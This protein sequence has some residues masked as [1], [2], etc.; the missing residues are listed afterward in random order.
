VK[1]NHKSIDELVFE[2]RD[3]EI[4]KIPDTKTRLDTIQN[5][6][7]P[8]L[9][10]LTK[11]TFRLL[12]EVYGFDPIQ[13]RLGF[14]YRPSHRKDAVKN[15]DYKEV[16]M[17]LSGTRAKATPLAVKSVQGKPYMFPPTYLLFTIG[18]EGSMRVEF[19]P[20]HYD[21]DRNSKVL[22]ARVLR[23]HTAKYAPFLAQCH[24][25]HNSTW[26]SLDLHEAMTID[27]IEEYGLWL[28]SPAYYFPLTFERGLKELQRAFIALY[29]LFDATLCAARG[30][31]HK[32]PAMLR[33]LEE[34]YDQENERENEES[35]K[36]EEIENTGPINLP[37]LQSYNFVRAGLWW[38][39]LARDKWRCCSCG[40]TAKDDGITLHVDHILPRSKGGADCAENLQ[41]LCQKCNIG[42]SNR[43]S[44]NLR[45]LDRAE[46]AC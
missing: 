46:L 31:N 27:S 34:W 20:F 22:L 8:R 5:Y 40:R 23:A 35:E 26:A 17:G 45:N 12:Q 3:T 9:D 21:L 29:P 41:A 32:L 10:V 43:D 2:T 36:P 30:E 37:E 44:T 13:K 25:V 4:F 11:E 6:F 24:V 28:Y 18:L 14:V 19:R 38:E 16:Y 33:R 7:F 42:K 1:T 15:K 39:V